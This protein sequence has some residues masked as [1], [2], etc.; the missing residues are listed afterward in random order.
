MIRKVVSGASAFALA[1]GFIVWPLQGAASQDPVRVASGMILGTREGDLT[2]YKGRSVT[3]TVMDLTAVDP[4]DV[5]ADLI[6]S[7]SNARNGI[8]ARVDAPTTAVAAFSQADLEAARIHFRHDGSETAVA[9]FDVI[10]T[11][12]AG[13]SSGAPK[14]VAVTVRADR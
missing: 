4:D 14:T 5:A 3:V 6:Y 11:D 1:V 9:S 8:V 12:H 7:V 10:V 2:V 13:A